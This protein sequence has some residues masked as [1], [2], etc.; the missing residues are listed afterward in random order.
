MRDRP[1]HRL[2]PGAFFTVRRVFFFFS[3]ASPDLP[4]R[5]SPT[6]RRVYRVALILFFNYTFDWRLG[7][8]IKRESQREITL[9]VFC[10]KCKI[11]HGLVRELSAR[12]DR[13]SP[14]ARK[15]E[16]RVNGEKSGRLR[17]LVFFSFFVFGDEPVSNDGKY[18]TLYARRDRENREQIKNIHL[19]GRAQ[20]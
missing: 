20:N 5:G 11:F 9:M 13:I 1:T 14:T 3:R 19:L 4:V 12:Q 10:W 8:K 17:F 16:I 18:H 2:H 6:Y 7:F 15:I